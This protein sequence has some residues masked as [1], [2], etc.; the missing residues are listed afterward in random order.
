MER[1]GSDWYVKHLKDLRLTST[2]EAYAKDLWN[3]YQQVKA[4]GA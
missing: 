1:F 4:Y 3:Y 2:G